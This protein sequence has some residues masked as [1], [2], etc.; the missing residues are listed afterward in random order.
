METGTGRVEEV[1]AAT[2]EHEIKA[3]LL[4]PGVYERV[5]EDAMGTAQIQD[6][7][8]FDQ[9]FAEYKTPIF[10]YVRGRVGNPEQ[11]ADLVQDIFVKV[12]LAWGS[13]EGGRDLAPW[14]YRIARNTVISWLRSYGRSTPPLHLSTLATD[15]EDHLG[16]D[17]LE[18]V[19]TGELLHA[20]WGELPKSFQVLLRLRYDEGLQFSEIAR[21]LSIPEGTVRTQVSRARKAFR[22]SYLALERG[23]S[24][25]GA[26]QGRRRT[27]AAGRLPPVHARSA[28]H[29]RKGT[30]LSST[31]VP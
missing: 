28:G 3:S 17:M 26:S 4:C 15:L 18:T 7:R 23:A 16:A 27:S 2:M 6:T 19:H 24:L 29:A 11:A 14:L 13:L 20:A 21:V 12:Y 31:D 30:I 10:A 25:G 1:L 8:S 9:I 22:A 5:M